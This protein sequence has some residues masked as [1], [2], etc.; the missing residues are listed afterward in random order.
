M[1][2]R[3]ARGGEGETR[4]GAR[5]ARRRRGANPTF[6]RALGM[7]LVIAGAV[8][9]ELGPAAMI[10]SASTLGGT[11]TI[12]DQTSSTGASNDLLTV[13]LPA[14]A[15]C[16][17]DTAN[18]GYHVFSYLIPQGTISESSFATTLNFTGPPAGSP[19]EGLGLVEESNGDVWEAKSTAP[20]TALIL[21]I[22]ADFQW[23]QLVTQDYYPLDGSGGLL[24][25]A[26]GSGIWETGIAC[27]NSSGAI[28]DFWNTEVTFTE[29]SSDP[30]GFTWSAVPGLGTWTSGG[31]PPTTTTT[32]TPTTT[33]TAT[34]TATTPTTAP[35]STTTVTTSP[36]AVG[37]TTTTT[38]G[39]TTGTTGT[40]STGTGATGTTGGSTGASSNPGA[41][42]PK[43]SS[44]DA[45]S[46][47]SA[48]D[49]GPSLVGSS[50]ASGQPVSVTTTTALPS[51]SA[52][53][54]S[55]SVS[56]V[57]PRVGS[58]RLAAG[59]LVSTGSAAHVVIAVLFILIGLCMCI[60]GGF[61]KLRSPY[62]AGAPTR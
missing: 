57:Q 38:T 55:H 62:V 33:T 26:N 37:I 1:R 16:T 52:S 53:G 60:L 11:A 6:W 27:A 43:I 20:V 9:L 17:G 40:G 61:A 47:S 58:S 31:P 18:D 19:N 49:A 50:A 29:S 24:Y 28:S 3:H 51:T 15:A 42:T 56:G 22:P 13:S 46:N 34:T 41:S 7:A 39:A 36:A 8:P 25:D 35:T 44:T 2:P 10:A 4:R 32:T 45:A 59:T 5:H 23:A 48:N 12:I 54:S 14:Q 21:G 30:N